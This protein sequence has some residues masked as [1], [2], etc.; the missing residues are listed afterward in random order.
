MVRQNTS[1]VLDEEL[2][3]LYNYYKIEFKKIKLIK[4]MYLIYIHI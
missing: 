3:F 2:S 1:Q 4:N